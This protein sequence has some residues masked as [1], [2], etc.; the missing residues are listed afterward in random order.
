[1]TDRHKR[2]KGVSFAS[3]VAFAG[4]EILDQLRGVWDKRFYTIVSE[5]PKVDFT[6]LTRV[7]KYRGDR[8]YGILANIGMLYRVNCMPTDVVLNFQLRSTVKSKRASCE[9]EEEK[10]PLNYMGYVHDG[11]GIAARNSVNLLSNRLEEA[12]DVHT[13]RGSRLEIYSSVP[14]GS[15]REKVDSQLSFFELVNSSAVCSLFRLWLEN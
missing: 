8:Q 6:R 5:E 4:K 7:L 10:V 1:M 14:C 12:G 9:F 11:L 2:S 15:R 3:G 13:R